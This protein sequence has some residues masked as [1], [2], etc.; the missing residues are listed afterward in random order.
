MP[1]TNRARRADHY[2]SIEASNGGG[3]GNSAAA[4]H[5][6]RRR[7]QQRDNDALGHNLDREHDALEGHGGRGAGR[8]VGAHGAGR[9][10]QGGSHGRGGGRAAQTG[11]GGAPAAPAAGRGKSKT[12]SV[13][14]RIRSLTRLMNKPV[15]VW[16]S[17]KAA[18]WPW[19][20][21]AVGFLNC[22]RNEPT[23][24]EGD[25]CVAL[26]NYCTCCAWHCCVRLLRTQSI[27]VVSFYILKD[28]LVCFVY[29]IRP[30]GCCCL[31]VT[32]RLAYG[33]T[34]A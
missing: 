9:G 25:P 22:C 32:R 11:G 31:F 28:V 17:H 13:K 18:A 20:E 24:I 16:N 15:R 19:A 4:A 34:P 3:N 6:G 30:A 33:T 2:R 8:R 12:P 7:P 23:N 29:Y 1:H 26:P 14:N 21:F 5:G 10:R 27:F